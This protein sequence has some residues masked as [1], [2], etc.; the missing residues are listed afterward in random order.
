MEPKKEIV[1]FTDS[2]GNC[3]INRVLSELT[4]VWINHGHKV[5]VAYIDKG[6]NGQSDFAWRPEIELI[7]ISCGNNIASIY[8][9]LTRTFIKLLRSR[10]NAVAVSL[11]VMTNFAIGAAAPFVRNRIVIS[12]RNDPSRRPAGR[13]KQFFRD[14]AFKQAD[15]LVLQTEDVRKYYQERIHRTGVVIPNP[16]NNNL[17]APIYGKCNRRPVIVTASRLNK[18]KNLGMLIEAFSRISSKHPEY[19]VEIFGRGDEKEN[20]KRRA[21]ELSVADK[22]IFK[23]FS[24][25]I[26]ENIKDCSIYVCSSDY[27][28]ISNALLEALGLGLPTISTD[29]PVG[30]SKLL[31]ENDVNGILV[32]VGD[33]DALSAQ[34]DRLIDNPDL[35][36]KLSG[37]AVGVR[38]KYTAERIAQMWLDNM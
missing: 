7:G 35:A 27:E 6:N 18:Q 13:I 28:G 2:M 36:E 31:I 23:G 9:N 29:C 12:D 10:P 3:G 37:N 26:Y 1:I 25:N 30:G 4:D 14:M 34:L 8:F 38:D 20:L 5:S 22:V 19:T 21:K 32:D 17:P 16:I 24:S 11:S 33:V 15:V